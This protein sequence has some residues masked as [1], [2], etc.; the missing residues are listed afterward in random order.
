MVSTKIIIYMPALNEGL[1][2]YKVLKS[3]PKIILDFSDVELLVINDGSTENTEQESLKAKA[4]VINHN[5]NKG[6]GNA[7]QTAVNYSL[8]VNA[9]ILVS[10]D[11]DGQFDANQIEDMIL[12]I[13]RN[14]G[15]FCIGNR[16]SNSKPEK[17]P[18]LKYW[19]NRQ[20]SRIVSFVGNTKI[21]DASCGFRAYSRDCLLSLNLQGGF[22]YTHETI[23]DLIDKGYRVTQVPVNVKY[24]EERVSRI[25]NNLF[26]YAINTSLIIFKCLKDY[27]PLQFF[28]TIAL[29]VLGIAFIMGSFVLTHWITS[30]TITPYKSLGI[31]A[32][33]LSGMSLLLVI[34]AFV[35]DMLN[36][37]R[38][39]Q[40]KILYLIKKDYFE[41]N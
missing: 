19:G 40:E 24:F 3:I 22:T 39:N 14:E 25:A 26:K 23:L 35:A 20:I 13:L 9:D 36:R 5:Y 10:I 7:F 38:T 28:L 31:I 32:L 8:K 33:S 27:K 1:T 6:V 12:P 2:I 11:S 34:L 37:I 17:M 30:G 15:D 18:K 21:K 4:T 41:K 16:F 29:L